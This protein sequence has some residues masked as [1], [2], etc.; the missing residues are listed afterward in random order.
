MK[1]FC[2]I[3]VDRRNGND[4]M[5]KLYERK[6]IVDSRNYR[7]VNLTLTPG[8]ILARFIEQVVC[9][10]LE[11]KEVSTRNMFTKNDVKLTLFPL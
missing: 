8:R 5:D 2:E 3:R 4:P 9:I 7:L 11:K 10:L 6:Q 1:F